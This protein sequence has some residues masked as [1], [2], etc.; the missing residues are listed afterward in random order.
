MKNVHPKVSIVEGYIINKALSFSSIHF[1]GMETRFT[2]PKRND[3]GR[4]VVKVNK[5]SLFTQDVC[6]IC[7]GRIG[8]LPNELLWKAN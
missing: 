7:G 3:D 2:R 5:L 8:T 1:Q 6:P 4:N